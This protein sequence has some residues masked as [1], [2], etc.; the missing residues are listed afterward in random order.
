MMLLAEPFGAQD[1]LGRAQNYCA[2]MFAAT[3]LVP[4]TF[5]LQLNA[6]ERDSAKLLALED[7]EVHAR[8]VP[9]LT[10]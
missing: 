10:A 6:V 3:T 7:G 2:L 1:R 5:G 8:F 4:F 9:R